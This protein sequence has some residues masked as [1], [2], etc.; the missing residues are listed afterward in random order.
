ME[1]AKDQGTVCRLTLEIVKTQRS[2]TT[3]NDWSIAKASILIAE[4]NKTN[5]LIV[6]K[7]L[8]QT[9]ADLCF[10]NDG[11]EAVER[12]HSFKPDLILMDLAMPHKSG[13][14]ATKDIRDFEHRTAVPEI[15]I[16]ALTANAFEENKRQCEQVGM[17]GFLSKPVNRD[18]LILEL[19]RAGQAAM[20]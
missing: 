12:Y 15:P 14:E 16:I 8:D 18:A 4:D 3:T 11:V 1:S 20:P 2:G 13:L 19:N 17:N 10:A 9:G 6:K 7:M 5:Q